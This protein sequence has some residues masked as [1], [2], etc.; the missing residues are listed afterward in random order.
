MITH[1][2]DCGGMIT[3]IMRNICANAQL[4]F[5]TMMNSPI[6]QWLADFDH[7][8]TRVD[9]IG[10]LIIGGGILTEQLV[11]KRNDDSANLLWFAN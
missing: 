10:A 1:V 9:S 4:V 7:T 11:L 2:S 5:D 3:C 8:C 6:C